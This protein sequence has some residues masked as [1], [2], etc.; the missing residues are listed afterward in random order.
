MKLGRIVVL[1]VCA[2][3]AIYLVASLAMWAY[4]GR[5]FDL[6]T[7]R[8]EEWATAGGDAT[9][10]QD[11]VES[12]GWLV[13]T[14]ARWLERLELVT[15]YRQEFDFRVDACV[16]IAANRLYRQPELER[17]EIVRMVCDDQNPFHELLPRLCRWAGLRPAKP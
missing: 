15:V 5:L 8:L 1:A 9:R 17:P 14:Q 10:A 2:I 16:K 13:I 12:C 4:R 6:Y 3:A 7:H 11:L